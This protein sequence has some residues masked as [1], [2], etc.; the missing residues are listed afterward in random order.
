MGDG[1]DSPSLFGLDIDLPPVDDRIARINEAVKQDKALRK[2]ELPGLT[3]LLDDYLAPDVPVTPEDFMRRLLHV[4]RAS[5]DDTYQVI[6]RRYSESEQH[7]LDDF[8]TGNSAHEAGRN[9]EHGHSIG[10]REELQ[11]MHDASR[12][13]LHRPHII[14][15]IEKAFSWHE[16]WD[17][18]SHMTKIDIGIYENDSP[19]EVSAST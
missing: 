11:R 4:F 2:H 5:S 18:A 12:V 15:A 1:S 7:V 6:L 10:V 9:L 14:E 8:V 17:Q 3:E 13:V 16:E 19:L